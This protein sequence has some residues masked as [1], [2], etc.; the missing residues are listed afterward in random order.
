[1]NK[2]FLIACL[3]FFARISGIMK[4]HITYFLNRLSK[5]IAI[6]NRARLVLDTNALYCL[7]NAIFQP[8]LNY[9][10]GVWGNT[11]KNS[12]FR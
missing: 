7:C 2:C 3:C 1:M 6:I 5:S 11:C 8:H 10:I 4:D 12:I 9:C